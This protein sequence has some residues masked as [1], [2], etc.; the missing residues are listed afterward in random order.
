[1][2]LFSRLR[3]TFAGAPPAPA[4]LPPAAAEPGARIEAQS[5]RSE[6]S[7]FPAWWSAYNAGSHNNS[8][9][10][11]WNPSFGSADS[12]LLPSRDLIVARI[13]DV[14]RNDPI[15]RA[16]VE[17]LV[18]L[19]V[20]HGLHLVSKPDPVALGISLDEARALGKA[21]Q[22]QW[23]VFALSPHRECD[24]QG[25]LSVNGLFRLGV[26]SRVTVGETMA[27]LDW[28]KNPLGPYR[29]CILMV[30][31]DRVSNPLGEIDSLTRRG[32]VE[33]DERGAPIGYHVRQAHWGDWWAWGKAWTWTY[34]PRRTQWGRPVFVHAFE[35]EREGQTKGVSPFVSLVNRLRM[36]GK[37]ADN[38]LAAAAAN[39]LFAAFVT[40]DLPSEEVRERL[41]ASGGTLQDRKG[42]AE[43]LLGWYSKFPAKVGGV[44]IPVMLP[45]SE[46]KMNSAPRQTTAFPH[47]QAAFL[48]TLAAA[49]G[50]SYE[51][52]SSDWSKTNYSSA[53]AALNEVWRFIRRLRSEF[54]EQ[55]VEPIYYAFL[56]EAFDRGF[57]AAPAGAPS[58]DECPA[59]YMRAR[60][61]GPGRGIV[62][63][64]KEANA[65]T[66]RLEN[67]TSTWERECAE[68]GE[69][70]EDVFEQIAIETAMLAKFGLSRESIVR[71]ANSPR[72]P[73]PTS[74]EAETGEASEESQE[75]AQAAEEAAR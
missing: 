74:E 5:A 72:T 39:A 34:V 26:R 17:R 70:F 67:L 35:P 16:G 51:L 42:W 44:R 21:I 40:S 53:R 27:A 58:F 46:I 65:A 10:A 45:G 11:A 64:L 56:E 13:R 57:V 60:W 61:I 55:F 49:L 20:G 30:D 66:V 9:T 23:R 62:D 50:L 7:P 41:S 12:D 2:G 33:L 36:V 71:A 29:T 54:V 25:R 22:A 6:A 48:Q 24:A 37:F 3:D 31:P 1:M 8:D 68:Q 47:F 28:R 63:P 52:L 32:G 4:G 38:E 43:Y 75:G 14:C 69:D 19:V 59:A 18:D 15:A 73:K